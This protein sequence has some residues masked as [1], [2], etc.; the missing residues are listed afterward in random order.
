MHQELVAQVVVRRGDR[1]GEAPLYGTKP[2]H[3]GAWS[4]DSPCQADTPHS[5]SPGP[6]CPEGSSHTVGSVCSH[7]AQFTSS[8]LQETGQ[9]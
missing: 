3:D 6:P 2:L 4:P 9:P 7:A 5:H 1:L 8:T